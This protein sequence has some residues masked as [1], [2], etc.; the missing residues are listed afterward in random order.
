MV[1]YFP[2]PIAIESGNKEVILIYWVRMVGIISTTFLAI[3]REIVQATVFA[4]WK[5]WNMQLINQK[6][7][8]EFGERLDS[9]FQRIRSSLL[10]TQGFQ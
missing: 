6:T 10:D 4:F 2:K 1:P 3:P 5:N 8:A 7:L 9:T